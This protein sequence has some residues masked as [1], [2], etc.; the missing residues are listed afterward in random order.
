M[1]ESLEK[2]QPVLQWI[3]TYINNSIEDDNGWNIIGKIKT[4]GTNIFKDFYK[5]HEANLKE[6]LSNADDF[7]VYETTLR[8]RRNDI[9]KTFNSKAKSILNE[10]KNANLDIPSNY[11][12]GLYK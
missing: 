5:A 3:S 7:K 6:Q 1:I 8:K 2:G 10:I 11:R 12:S 9:R 4:F